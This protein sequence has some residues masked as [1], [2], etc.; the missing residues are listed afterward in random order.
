[1]NP[2]HSCYCAT[3]D[4]LKHR[5]VTCPGCGVAVRFG[6]WRTSSYIIHT[7][8]EMHSRLRSRVHAFF[9]RVSRW[10]DGSAPRE[11]AYSPKKQVELRLPPEKVRQY[12]AHLG[13]RVFVIG[14]G[15]R[16]VANEKGVV[17]GL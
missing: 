14:S 4:R 11:A 17:A 3:Y 7:L 1:M 8:E 12:A 5:G 2:T 6:G 9:N 16:C 10:L 15:D 13:L